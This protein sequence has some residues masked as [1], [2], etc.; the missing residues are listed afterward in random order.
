MSTP[1]PV[2][3][4]ESNP[5]PQP[6]FEFIFAPQ[7]QPEPSTPIPTPTWVA[8]GP[9]AVDV[10]I[11]LYHHIDDSNPVSQYYVSPDVFDEQ[12]KLLSDWGCITITTDLL[13]K[14]ITDGAQLP[15]CTFIITFDDGNLDNYTN[16]YPIMKKYGFIGVLY[17]VENYIDADSY[18]TSGQI[19][20]LLAA[21][22]E[23]GSHTMNHVDLVTAQ[24]EQ[25]LYEINNSKRSLEQKFGVSVITL[26]YPFGEYDGGVM[27]AVYSSGY[28]AA[29][30]LGSSSSQ[31]NFELYGLHRR[32]V[33]GGMALDNFAA[34]LPWYDKY[35]TMK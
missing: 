29:M 16:A 8:Q 20:E 19:H 30:G 17:V 35:S 31:S 33:R 25:R 15:A 6:P 21:G 13:V 34:L 4:F 2:I 1:T 18:M 22:W 3:R 28:I 9:G 11:L 32:A 5:T 23:L 14:A 27:D 24:P 10:P 7:L 26:S 12:L